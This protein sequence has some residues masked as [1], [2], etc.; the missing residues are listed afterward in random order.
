MTGMRSVYQP[1]FD[2]YGVDLVLQGHIHAYERTKPMEYDSLITH[3]DTFDYVSPKGQVY[4]TVGT[5][6]QSLYEYTSSPEM[7]VVQIEDFGFLQV[8]VTRTSLIGRFIDNND[9]V[10]DSFAIAKI[11]DQIPSEPEPEPSTITDT[12]ATQVNTA[13]YVDRYQQKVGMKIADPDRRNMDVVRA[14]FY[15]YKGSSIS[16]SGTLRAVIINLDNNALIA[17][18]TNTLDRNTLAPAY[19]SYEFTF[20]AGATTPINDNFFIGL[21]CMG[22]DYDRIYMGANKNNPYLDGNIAVYRGGG[23]LERTP[24]VVGSVSMST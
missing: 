1:L 10:R 4:I 18:S 12:W 5:G 23:W 3:P 16:A 22:C 20:S 9:T 14:T 8:D 21:E 11:G 24:D 7:S 17:T 13:D 19:Q 6:G 15:L 2:S